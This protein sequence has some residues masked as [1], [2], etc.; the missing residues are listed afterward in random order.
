MSIFD[1]DRTITRSGTYAKWLRHWMRAAAPARAALVPLTAV[2]GAGFLVGLYG[3]GRLKQLNHRLLMG[4]RV[5]AAD[6]ERE[7]ERFA[8]ILDADQVY[9]D[10]RRRIAAEHA[11]GRRVIWATASYDF[12][13]RPLATR[14]GV[15]E[16]VA[17]AAQ[18][19]PGCVLARLD[20]ENCYGAAKLR[21][22][23]AYLAA[24]GIDRTQAHIRFFSDHHSDE[25]VFAWADEA[26]AVNPKPPMRALAAKRDWP[27][28][29]WD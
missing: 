8:A 10:A 12:Y 4:G 17:T 2:T 29:V 25:P 19:A 20:G 24:Q 28:L 26:Y 9:S 5:G 27:I 11:E 6:V 22:I 15:D 7:A 3:R 18:R 13:V 23:E 14:L 1:M 16:I 21:K